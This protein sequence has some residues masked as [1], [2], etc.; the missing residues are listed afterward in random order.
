PEVIEQSN[1]QPEEEA[2]KRR[3]RCAHTQPADHEPQE[4]HSKQVERVNYGDEYGK[5]QARYALHREKIEVAG[6]AE[7]IGLKEW[8]K[9]A[10]EVVAGSQVRCPGQVV[11]L[12]IL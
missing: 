4:P 6:G 7:I 10:L 9:S 12:V 5:I 11:D 3:G 8:R 1:V 2:G